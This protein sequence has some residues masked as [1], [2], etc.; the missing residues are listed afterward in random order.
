[1]R[2]DSGQM[3]QVSFRLSTV[4]QPTTRRWTP[5]GASFLARPEALVVNA[6]PLSRGPYRGSGLSRS[7]PTTSAL[8]HT[9]AYCR[10]WVYQRIRAWW[11]GAEFGAPTCQLVPIGPIK[12]LAI[13]R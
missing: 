5:Q 13:G 1:M 2:M 12:V 7:I 8:G 9:G 11:R 6:A 10:E 4:K 3:A